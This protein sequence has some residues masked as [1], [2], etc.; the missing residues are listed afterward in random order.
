MEKRETAGIQ[1][2]DGERRKE[3]GREME[4]GIVM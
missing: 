3:L 4:Q 2:Y 1:G